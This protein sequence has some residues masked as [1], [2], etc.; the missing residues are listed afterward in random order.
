MLG[1]EGECRFLAGSL[2]PALKFPPIPLSL[3]LD[4][5]HSCQLPSHQR[6]CFSTTLWSPGWVSNCEWRGLGV[7]LGTQEK[8][9]LCPLPVA[10][11]A[12]GWAPAEQPPSHADTRLPLQH[13]EVLYEDFHQEH[14]HHARESLEPRVPAGVLGIMR[15]QQCLVW[16]LTLVGTLRPWL[17]LSE[18]WF[19]QLKNEDYVIPHF[20]VAKMM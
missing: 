14:R 20:W 10:V 11:S 5:L 16:N 6:T 17:F 4:Y 15:T 1:L 8:V 3:A 9:F 18:P 12:R 2:Q 19:P 7:T 13:P